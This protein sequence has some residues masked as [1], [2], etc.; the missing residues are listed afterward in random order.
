MRRTGTFSEQKK[1]QEEGNEEV[2]EKEEKDYDG[3]EE[4]DEDEG[5][6]HDK[7]IQKESVEVVLV[8]A[9]KFPTAWFWSLFHDLVCSILYPIQNNDPLLVQPHGGH[10]LVKHGPWK[11]EDP[12]EGPTLP[13]GKDIQRE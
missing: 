7:E 2:E 9:H 4:E 12:V 13:E 5:K 10:M 6:D 8:G 11:S 3:E 1:G